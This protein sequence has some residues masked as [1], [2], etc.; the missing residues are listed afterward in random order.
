M[1]RDDVANPSILFIGAVVNDH[2]EPETARFVST[3][4]YLSMPIEAI[5]DDLVSKVDHLAYVLL[6]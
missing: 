5:S 3:I 2:A 6:G 1:G 4:V